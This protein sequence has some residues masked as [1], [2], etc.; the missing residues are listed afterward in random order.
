MN[1]NWLPYAVDSKRDDVR[2][3]LHPTA[4]FRAIWQQTSTDGIDLSDYVSQGSQSLFQVEITLNWNNELFGANQPKVNQLLEIELQGKSHWI[5]VV[6]AIDGYTI[7]RGE[8]QM[9]LIAKSRDSLDIWR[10][11]K[12]VSDFYPA[13]S[14]VS[15]IAMDI[16]EM[17]GM[18]SDE[19]NIPPTSITTVHHNL[20][21][22]GMSAW[23]MLNTILMPVGLIP[24]M[25][26]LGRLRVA[27]KELI[28][29]SPDV[30]LEEER[31]IRVNA[32]RNRTPTSRVILRWLDFNFTKVVQQG[33]KLADQVITAGYF[34]S[35][36]RKDIL[37][38]ADGTQRAE[39]TYMMV[40]QSANSLIPVCAEEY[41]Q[42][43]I[44]SGRIT[45]TSYMWTS[46]ILTMVLAI[47]IASVIPDNVVT[48]G[49]F[50]QEGAT[51]P[52]GRKI[53]AAAEV[54]LLLVMLS[55]GTGVY[56]IWGNPYDSVRVRNTTEAY[57]SNAP[58]WMDN[59]QEIENDLIMNEAHAQAVAVREL[60][61]LARSANKWTV[62]IV[63]DPSIEYGDLIEF[64]DGNIMFVEDV[65]RS[66][67]RGT[68]PSMEL[69]GFLIS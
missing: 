6:D 16:A 32:S 59:A 39:N 49:L 48:G 21:L 23:E 36:I 29:R 50:V 3:I 33:R 64:P 56:E 45:L 63:D 54:A 1:T 28:G 10:T 43:T 14:E 31:V 12:R 44:N 25:D 69:S 52:I 5:G 67:A 34:S 4:S 9:Q 13:L 41:E 47:Q 38:S 11:S 2:I 62:S 65:R 46:A 8:R 66:I 55:V 35:H 40:R 60:V 24:Y 19:I 51:V 17:V 20:Q 53:Q 68:D 58:A 26:G 30:V 42:L 22:A 61:Y 7:S 18:L 57:D 27:N 15:V 37:F